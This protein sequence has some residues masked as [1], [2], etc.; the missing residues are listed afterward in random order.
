[1]RELEPPGDAFEPA[2]LV[3]GGR[4]DAARPNV[5]PGVGSARVREQPAEDDAG[6]FLCADR[7]Q[8]RRGAGRGQ[9]R[10]AR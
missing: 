5:K 1:M 9:W 2:S 6:Y 10:R 7:R 3:E 4:V 8:P